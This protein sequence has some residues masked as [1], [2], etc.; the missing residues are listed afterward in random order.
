MKKIFSYVIKR[1]LLTW[2]TDDVP[3][4]VFSQ[5]DN[6]RIISVKLFK[7]KENYAL[8]RRMKSEGLSG[9]LIIKSLHSMLFKK[10]LPYLT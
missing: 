9:W 6:D 10:V 8:I 1:N 7:I 2:M 4:D 5:Q 3:F